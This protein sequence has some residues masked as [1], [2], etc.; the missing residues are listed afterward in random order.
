MP[1]YEFACKKCIRFVEKLMTFEQHENTKNSILCEYCGK[2]MKQTVRFNGHIRLNGSW[3]STGYDLLD[4]EIARN[5][6]I[7]KR[8]E[9]ESYEMNA[10]N[11]NIKEL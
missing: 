6:D 3:S 11:N 2:V 5:L 8:I 9:N 1:C 10:K 7:E 4:S